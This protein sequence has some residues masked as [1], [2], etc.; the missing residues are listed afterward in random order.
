MEENTQSTTIIKK[1]KGQSDFY[2][3]MSKCSYIS[4][5]Q[6]KCKSI[7]NKNSQFCHHHIPKS[8]KQ[9]TPTPSQ[10]IN[11]P[12]VVGNL[13][14][15]IKL[16]RKYLNSLVSTNPKKMEPKDFRI[17]LQVIEQI[18]KL[19]HS[20][21]TIENQNKIFS[22][23]HKIINAFVIKV[24]EIISKHIIDENIKNNLVS[25]LMELGNLDNENSDLNI[26]L[27][28]LNPKSKGKFI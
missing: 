4:P 20:L 26:L 9:I 17:Q 8:E 27:K 19:V 5:T 6:K 22:T 7:A 25:E 12:S 13:G 2:G 10:P 28:K 14:F 16:L 3:M 1:H 15:E 11:N 18:R 23:V 21:S 24:G